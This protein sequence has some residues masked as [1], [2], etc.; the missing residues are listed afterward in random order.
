MICKLLNI[1]W[2]ISEEVA[3]AARGDRCDRNQ[4]DIIIIKCLFCWPESQSWEEQL[5]AEQKGNWHRFK[6][7]GGQSEIEQKQQ[8]HIEEIPSSS[9]QL[10]MQ[11]FQKHEKN[12]LHPPKTQTICC[13]PSRTRCL[14]SLAEH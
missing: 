11:I 12:I 2:E 10:E 5:L 7:E 6:M 3:A 9:K 8:D 13:E 4:L 14:L 1:L